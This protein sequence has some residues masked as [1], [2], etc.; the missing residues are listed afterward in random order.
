MTTYVSRHVTTE[1]V[2]WTGENLDE[3]KAFAGE[4]FI[5]VR[6]SDGHVWVRNAEG[7]A[8]IHPGYWLSRQRAGQPLVLRS[9]YA[10]SEMWEP[11]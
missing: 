11:V 10:F 9:P 4:D 6:T 3:V 7:P 1:A 8:L 2:Q 5:G